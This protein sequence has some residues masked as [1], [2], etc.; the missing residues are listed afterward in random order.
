[1]SLQDWA[2][3]NEHPLPSQLRGLLYRTLNFQPHPRHAIR[4]GCRTTLRAA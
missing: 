2:L 4:Q 3:L 1:M